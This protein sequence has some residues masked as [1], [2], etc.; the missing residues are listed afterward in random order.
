MNKKTYIRPTSNVVMLASEAAL[1]S[2]SVEM[3]ISNDDTETVSTN[4]DLWS[5]SRNN[6]SPIWGSED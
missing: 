1:L 4:D 3:S 2:A 5:N 6:N